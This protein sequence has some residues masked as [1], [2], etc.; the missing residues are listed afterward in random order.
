M[1]PEYKTAKRVERSETKRSEKKRKPSTVRIALGPAN[2]V[3]LECRQYRLKA[4]QAYGGP[5]TRS[6]W[7]MLLGKSGRWVGLV[8]EGY[9]SCSVEDRERMRET[10]VIAERRNG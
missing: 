7:G 8:E 5:L 3:A 9:L 1:K 2:A 10:V 6:Q 4:Q